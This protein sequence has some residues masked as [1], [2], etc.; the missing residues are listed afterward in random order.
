MLVNVVRPILQ[1]ANIHRFIDRAT[2]MLT[3][4]TIDELSCPFNKAKGWRA[5]DPIIVA[6]GNHCIVPAAFDIDRKIITPARGDPLP[7]RRFIIP[8]LSDGKVV[9]PL[10]R[11]VRLLICTY[12]MCVLKAIEVNPR[13]VV[14]PERSPLPCLGLKVSPL[15][16]NPTLPYNINSLVSS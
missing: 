12:F 7:A 10:Q 15:S 13:T 2:H 11:T 5:A 14:E 6:E 8:V 3:S 1:Y 9:E 16:V 4:H